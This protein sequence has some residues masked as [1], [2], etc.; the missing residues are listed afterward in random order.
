MVPIEILPFYSFAIKCYNCQ[1]FLLH[2]PYH[3]EHFASELSDIRAECEPVEIFE[4]RG[5]SFPLGGSFSVN[6]FFKVT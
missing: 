6:I 4:V 2:L 3:R 5:A 1:V